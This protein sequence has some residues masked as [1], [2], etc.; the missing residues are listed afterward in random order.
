[1]EAGPQAKQ[2][3]VV[4]CLTG[5]STAGNLLLLKPFNLLNL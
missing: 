4:R 1:M 3:A 5:N 2:T